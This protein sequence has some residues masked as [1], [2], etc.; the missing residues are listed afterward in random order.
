MGLEVWKG[1]LEDIGEGAYKGGDVDFMIWDS[2]VD[3]WDDR[4]IIQRF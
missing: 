4:I 2:V 1:Y 3:K